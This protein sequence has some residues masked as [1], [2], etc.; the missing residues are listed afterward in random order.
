MLGA[1]LFPL[2]IFINARKEVESMTEFEI[3]AIVLT[4]IEIIV[5]LLTNYIKK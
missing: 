3:I 4:V 1:R 5:I 2:C